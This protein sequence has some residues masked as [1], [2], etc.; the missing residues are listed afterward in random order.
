MDPVTHFLTG[1]VLGRSGF[2]RKAAYATLAMT[3]AAEAPDLDVLW[4]FRGPVAAFEHHRGITHTFLATPFIALITVVVVWCI[5]RLRK[6]PTKAPVRWGLLWLFA[7]IA[8]LSHLL[9]DFTNNYGLRPFFP[10]NPRWYSWDIVFIVEPLILVALILAL[11]LPWILGLADREIGA[12]RAVFLGRAWAIAALI[13]IGLLYAVRNGEHSHALNLVR[14][15]GV[16]NGRI[17]RVAAQPYPVNPFHWYVIVETPDNYQTAMVYTRADRIDT[18]AGETVYKPSVTKA[19]AAAKQSWL[20][21]VYLDWSKFP[22]TEDK[23]A[24]SPPGYNVDPPQRDWHTVQ[25]RDL[26]FGYPVLSFKAN[27][28]VLSGWVYVG[29]Q[30]EIEGMFMSGE[31]QK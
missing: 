15:T 17:L 10:F 30:Q 4:A 19:V 22:V 25:F 5:H 20:G 18:D 12:K 7:L 6:K 11:V 31:E 2:N 1:A 28:S 24:M 21:R 27:D 14:N 16:V 23:G 9:L 13:F 8:A 26:R 29:P 3:L